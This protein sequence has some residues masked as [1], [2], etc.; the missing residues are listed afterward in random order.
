MVTCTYEF[1]SKWWKYHVVLYRVKPRCVK[2]E[3]DIYYQ[4]NVSFE[5]RDG[6]YH[7]GPDIMNCETSDTD[8]I[9]YINN[10]T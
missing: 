4:N 9:V 2:V 8:V 10:V 1:D 6:P 5:D 7:S 3:G